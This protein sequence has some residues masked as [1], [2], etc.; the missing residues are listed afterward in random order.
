MASHGGNKGVRVS[1]NGSPNYHGPKRGNNQFVLSGMILLTQFGSKAI[2]GENCYIS[3]N[4]TI[5]AKIDGYVC[6]DK[7]FVNKKKK[8]IISV[9]PTK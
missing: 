4:H 8:V 2:A 1:R 9:K 5:H 7:G 6:F 3:K